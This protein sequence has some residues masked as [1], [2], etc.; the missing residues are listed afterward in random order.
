LYLQI[1]N[2]LDKQTQ[3]IQKL[4]KN[5]QKQVE[6][7]QELRKSIINDAVTGKVKVF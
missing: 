1:A 7:Y 6:L 4:I 5:K 2:Y 3:N